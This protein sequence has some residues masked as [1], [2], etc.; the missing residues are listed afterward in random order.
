MKLLESIHS[1][2]KS[3]RAHKSRSFL[4]MLGIIIGI[5]AVIIVMSVGAGA[6]SLVLNQIQGI[7]SNLVGVLP[8][9]AEDEGPPATIFGI[10]VTSL[11]Y[12]DAK[13]LAEKRNVKNVE[14]VASYVQGVGTVQYKNQ[15]V[16]STFVGTTASFLEVESTTVSTGRFFDEAEEQSISRV[17]VLGSELAKDL[18]DNED[19]VGKDIRIK[20]ERFK[21]IG[22][23]EERGTLFFVN[24]DTRVFIPLK[25]AQNLLLGI[26]HLSMIRI[27]VDKDENVHVATEEIRLTLRE[28][29]DIANPEEDDF[30]A[31][32]I[33]QA[34]NVFTDVT[35]SLRFF[36][37]AIAAI[38]LFVGG[39]GIM[40]IMLVSV[41]E[42]IREVGLRKAVG[43]KRVDI[44]SQ[45][46]IET[47]TLSI[48]GG[49]IGIAIGALFSGAV[50]VGANFLGY[51]WTYVVTFGS[52]ALA[53]GFS[54]LV[55]LTFGIYPAWKA[56]QLDPLTALRYE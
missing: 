23:M 8:G 10:V 39:I 14:S 42:R 38:A 16:N 7:G 50:A 19:P 27:K 35:N 26:D 40:N 47:L 41:N 18:F 49:A 22:V 46:L 9:K 31:R 36:L 17:A 45:F 52:V 21:V 15:D 33:Q 34:A 54:L 53:T 48:V 6:Q 4:T 25:T 11:T 28:R 43:A 24:Q 20:K 44:L 29:H 1:S 3:I 55:G 12:D 2:F 30:T 56:A 13:A 51:E 5:A 32:N 37:V